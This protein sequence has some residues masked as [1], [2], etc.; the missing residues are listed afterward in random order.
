MA[1]S[2]TSGISG[3]AAGGGAALRFVLLRTWGG[4][5]L[6]LLGMASFYP[7]PRQRGRGTILRSKMVEGARDSTRRLR[8]KRFVNACAPSTALRAVPLPRVAA[9]TGEDEDSL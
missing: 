3:S 5:F 1:S 8:R 2:G 7:P 9:H 4:L 6:L